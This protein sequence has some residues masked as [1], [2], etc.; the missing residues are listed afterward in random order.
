MGTDAPKGRTVLNFPEPVDPTHSPLPWERPDLRTVRQFV[1][2]DTVQAAGWCITG[3]GDVTYQVPTGRVAIIEAIRADCY[4][5]GTFA[6]HPLDGFNGLCHILV[7]GS[8]WGQEGTASF[9]QTETPV[10]LEHTFAMWDD[11]NSE[12]AGTFVAVRWDCGRIYLAE[13]DTFRA[14][15]ED[16]AW[17]GSLGNAGSFRVTITEFSPLDLRVWE[18][19]RQP[20]ELVKPG[21]LS[22]GQ[23]RLW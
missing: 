3:N 4:A 1:R 11:T 8:E 16:C 18:R 6:R 21:G 15:Q 20:G 10:V 5:S 9:S 22:I 23:T 12:A 13:G 19:W 7:N 17:L 2:G 14:F